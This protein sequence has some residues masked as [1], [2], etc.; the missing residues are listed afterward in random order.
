MF[1]RQNSRQFKSVTLADLSMSS[2]IWSSVNM[3]ERKTRKPLAK[4]R[5]VPPA[6]PDLVLGA[7]AI[8]VEIGRTGKA[9]HVLRDRGKLPFVFKFCGKL[10]ATRSGIRAYYKSLEQAALN[11]QIAAQQAAASA[12]E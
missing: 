12:A 10:A 4:R 6:D 1:I 2:K 7:D 11:D 5:R 3:V 8:G 9:V